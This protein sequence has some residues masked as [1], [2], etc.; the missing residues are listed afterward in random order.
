VRL[1]VHGGEY[2]LLMTFAFSYALLAPKDKD[3]YNPIMDLEKTLYTIVEG[4]L[5]PEMITVAHKSLQSI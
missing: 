2:T 3:H 4:R 5:E 1:V